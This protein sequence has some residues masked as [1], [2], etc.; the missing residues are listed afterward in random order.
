[1][2]A[3]ALTPEPDRGPPHPCWQHEGTA[4]S[5][6]LRETARVTESYGPR[7]LRTGRS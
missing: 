6:R 4:T 5:I 7:P 1:V 3:A 2:G